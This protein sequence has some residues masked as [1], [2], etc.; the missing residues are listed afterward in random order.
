MILCDKD[1]QERLG[2]GLS[3]RPITPEMIRPASVDLTL[4]DEPFLKPTTPSSVECMNPTRIKPK[5]IQCDR[6]IIQPREMLLAST[7]QR[8]ALPLDLAADVK[9]RSTMA[10]HGLQ[11]HAAG[12]VDPGFEGTITLELVN[13]A[14]D[15]IRIE[16]KV[17]ICQMVFYQMTG[18]CEHGYGDLATSKYQGQTGATPAECDT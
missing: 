17:R 1:I 8:I 6:Q 16:P 11:V 5:P 9:G 14:E 18:A 15:P 4:Q 13:F 7:E 12:F 10:R 2:D 3:I